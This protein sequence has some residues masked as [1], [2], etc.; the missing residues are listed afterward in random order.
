MTTVVVMMLTVCRESLAAFQMGAA[1]E[2]SWS[3]M[4]FTSVTGSYNTSTKQL[5]ASGNSSD[6]E[7]GGQFGPG[8]PG[9]HYGTGGTLGNPFS[10]TLTMNGVIVQSNG[11]VTNGGSVTVMFNA[12]APGSIG[13]DYGIPNNSVLLSG[14]V[15]AVQ[16]NATGAG[17]LDVMFAITGGA[18][19]NNNPS[20]G[21]NFAPG[22][23]G[24]MRFG[25]RTPPNGDFTT[26]FSLGSATL[27]LF[28]AAVPEPRY[29]T[30][31][32]FSL[33]LCYIIGARRQ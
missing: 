5:T 3:D 15:L 13:A 23:L 2:L 32:C 27:D 17:T 16:L 33:L 28:G 21:T 20:L 9:R 12:G 4:A 6:L 29:V 31:A 24:L 10:S 1:E 25:S 19:Q 22:L 8:F 7:I 26:G 11:N 14:N 18:L 30:F